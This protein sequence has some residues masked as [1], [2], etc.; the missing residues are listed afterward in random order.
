MKNDNTKINKIITD[1]FDGIKTDISS[2]LESFVNRAKLVDML[3][4]SRVDFN[5]AI[6]LSPN[7][8]IEISSKYNIVKVI[9][10]CEVGR[11]R[12]INKQDIDNNKGEYPI[13]SSQTSNNG[14]FGRINTFDFDGEY[15]TWTTDGIYAGTCSFRSGKFNCTN[16]CGTLKSKTK[17]INM[18]YL[19]Y[20]LNQ[21]TDDY[22][23]K[24]ANPK[25]MNNVMSNIKIPLPPLDIQEEIVKECQKVDDEVLKANE[26]ILKSKKEIVSLINSSTQTNTVKIGEACEL[27]AGKFVSA[28]NINDEN[29][30]DLYPCFG[31]NGLRGYVKTFTHDGIYPLIGR[32]GALCGNVILAQNKFHATEHAV[33][34]S[35]KMDL[36]VIWLY[37]KLAIMDLN[38]YKTGVA[39]PGLSVKNLNEVNIDIPPLETQKQIV[40]KIEKLELKINE[41]KSVI[42]SAKDLKEKVLRKYL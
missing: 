37:N 28:K 10:I 3:D 1:N 33:T 8:K 14:I 7:K 16:V 12:V 39:Q 4:F 27:K 2:E 15:V 13:Y 29:E 9:E 31:G 21:V 30:K 18:K 24:S 36:D 17:E 6:G 34:V 42:N 32:Q 41:A 26:I 35:A 40:S 20:A 11:G 38:Q 19:P 5:K 25:L 23:V 22:V